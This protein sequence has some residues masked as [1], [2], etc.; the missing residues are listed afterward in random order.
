MMARVN[1]RKRGGGRRDRMDEASVTRS[2]AGGGAGSKPNYGADGAPSQPPTTGARDALDQLQLGGTLE[3]LGSSA[4]NSRV[5]S[6]DRQPGPALNKASP[7][8][9]KTPGRLLSQIAAV[10]QRLRRNSS[11]GK[12]SG[13]GSRSSSPFSSRSSSPFSG[14]RE[15][16]TT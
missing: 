13:S 16:G 11:F 15:R 4:V 1:Q 8:T 3:P 7:S 6:S 9:K 2:K 10:G 5:S 12:V 14:R